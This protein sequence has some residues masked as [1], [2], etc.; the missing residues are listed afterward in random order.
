MSGIESPIQAQEAISIT[1]Q[2][3][4]NPSSATRTLNFNAH[5][6]I[7]PVQLTRFCSKQTLDVRTMNQYTRSLP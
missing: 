4:L 7:G 2:A 6:F 5:V 1:S 3:K